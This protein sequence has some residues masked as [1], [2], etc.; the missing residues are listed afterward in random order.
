MEAARLA[1]L[2]APAFCPAMPAAAARNANLATSMR[3]SLVNGKAVALRAPFCAASLVGLTG[4]IGFAGFFTTSALAT[5]A[6]NL[7]TPT[8]F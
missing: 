1:A 4:L 8:L 3:S 7:L 6:V 5:D 2:L